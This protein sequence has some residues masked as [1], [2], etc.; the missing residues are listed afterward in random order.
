MKE[1]TVCKGKTYRARISLSFIQSWVDNGVITDK[2][3]LAGFIDVNVWGTGYYRTAEG[4]WIGPD[5]TGGLPEEV[6][7]VVE[8]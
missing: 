1:F 8:V 4:T 6:T 7:E 5:T 2:L 3:I